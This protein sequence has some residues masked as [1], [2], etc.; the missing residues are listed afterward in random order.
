MRISRVRGSDL[1][2]AAAMAMLVAAAISAEMAWLHMREIQ[3]LGVICG[4]A[5][6]P[7]CAWCP[8]TVAFLLGGLALLAAPRLR[9]ATAVR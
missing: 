3:R 5:L 4:S 8:A 6:E 2:F 9:Q 7:H 1:R